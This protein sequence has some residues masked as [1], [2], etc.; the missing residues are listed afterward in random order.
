MLTQGLDDLKAPP[1]GTAV[2]IGVF[3]GV[4]LGHQR[5]IE[6]LVAQASKR[7]LVPTVLTFEP[8]PDSVLP[9]GKHP[10]VLTSTELKAELLGELGVEIV[11]VAEFN[12]RLADLT[13]ESFAAE[14]LKGRLDARLIVVGDGFRFGR[15]AVGTI[16]T[17][18]KQ[19][20]G[21]GF[22]VLSVPLMRVAGRPVSSTRA[23]TLIAEGRLQDATAVLGRYPR[24]SGEVSHGHGRGRRIGFPTANL[25]TFD[26]ASVPP[27]AVYAGWVTVGERRMACAVDIGVSPTFGDVDRREVH[28]HL[29][30]FSA[31]LYGQ[32]LEVEIVA[33]L[34]DE[35][36]FDSTEAL[37]RQIRQD[38][39]RTR[40]LLGNSE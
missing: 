17:L 33:K 5:I 31:T 2:S 19:G 3:D 15:G 27:P 25:V 20:G 24:I 30:E 18:K 14:I 1:A 37:S 23:R 36:R 11:V 7:S 16:E 13:A 34:R 40:Q 22:E 32:R 12:R 29:L 28:V 35:V 39:A 26:E 21:L 4:H 9:G 6:A 38:V 8:H 10:P